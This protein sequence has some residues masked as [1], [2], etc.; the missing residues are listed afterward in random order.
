MARGTIP[1]LQ[2]ALAYSVNRKND[3]EGVRQSLYDFLLYPTAGQ[4]QLT[5]FAN[6]LGQGGSSSPGLTTANAK[7]LADTN[8]ESAGQ[9]PAPKMFLIE[10]IEVQFEAGSVSTAATYTPQVVHSAAAAPA[11]TNNASVAG[12]AANDIDAIRRSGWLNLFVGSKTYLN[13][14]PI[15]RFP[16]KTRLE[17]NGSVSTN[18]ATTQA[19]EF[20]VAKWGGRPYYVEP[21]ILLPST[22]NF[23]VTLN[24]PVAV[25]TPSG[26][27]GRIGV[28]LDG[29][30]YRNSQ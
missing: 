29:Y 18:S 6:P 23:S 8:M 16:P 14:A 28:I 26:F 20:A 2:E 1:S 7:T 17:A 13:E 11:A 15:G 4:T 27:N 22:Q 19:I 5:F 24:W 9:L 25:A 12:G 30:L 3:V 21:A 10:S